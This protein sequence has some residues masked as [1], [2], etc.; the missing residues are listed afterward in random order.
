MN[1]RPRSLASAIRGPVTLITVGILFALNNFTPYGFDKT[2][3][4]LLI[5]FGLLSLIRRG[6]EPEP[7]VPVPP[8]YNYPPPTAG[9]GY[10][11]SSYSAPPSPP[12][13]PA[14][15][16]KGGFGTSAPPRPESPSGD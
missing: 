13:P 8:P 3:P 15:P 11:G 7:P 12:S 6:V 14:G 16:A 4:V 9:G 2:W 1:G 5:V 10:A